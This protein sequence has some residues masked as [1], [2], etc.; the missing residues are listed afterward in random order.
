[1]QKTHT[2]PKCQS[3]A[4]LFLSRVDLQVDK[5]GLVEAWRIARVPQNMEGFPLP[6]GEPVTAGIV[7][8]YICRGCGYTELYTR[9]PDAIPV[10]GVVVRALHGRA[11]TGPYR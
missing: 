4:I 6:G 5:Y 1:M 11:K 7:Q 10:D 3:I 8:A 2:C 9:D